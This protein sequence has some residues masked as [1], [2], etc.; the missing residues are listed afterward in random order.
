M[1]TYITLNVPQTLFTVF[2]AI[3]WGTAANAQPRWRAFAWPY[4]LEE[5][6]SLKRL[7]L[8]FAI[9]NVIPI[10]YFVGVLHLL[11]D[12]QWQMTTWTYPAGFKKIL[13]GLLPSF[14]AFGFYRLWLA[15]ILWKPKC[16]YGFD[17]SNIDKNKY[18]ALAQ[19]DPDPKWF[20]GN[21][22]AAIV[23]MVISVL[24]FIV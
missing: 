6:A 22:I 9:M 10:L 17:K 13:G 20:R 4:A 18:P 5:V 14:A 8:S 12:T 23:Y 3:C 7:V 1:N 24:P 19:N 21:L 15:I 11:S 2:F 16:F